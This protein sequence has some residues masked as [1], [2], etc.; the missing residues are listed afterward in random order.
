MKIVA[1]STMGLTLQ[2]AK[3]HSHKY[4]P[5]TQTEYYRVQAVFMGGYRPAQWIPQVER[6]RLEATAAQEAGP[7]P[8]M[9]GSIKRSPDA[10]RT[11]SRSRRPSV[12]DGPPIGW[13]RSPTR[14]ARMCE[15]PSRSRRTGG[16]R[17]SDISSTSSRPSCNPSRRRWPVCLPRSR[18][19]TATRSR[20]SRRRTRPTRLDGGTFRNPG[21]LRPPG[22][23]E[24]PCPDARRLS[25]SRPRGRA[26]G[27]VL[28][29]HTPAVPLDSVPE[30][31][32]HDR[33]S[34]GI[35]RVAD[36]TAAPA[37]GPRPGQSALAPSLRRRDR[38]HSRQLRIE[39]DSAEP[40]GIARL[41][42]DRVRRAGLVDQGDASADH[43]LVGLS[44]IEPR[45][46]RATHP[47]CVDPD[48]H[49][50]WRRRMAGSTPRRSGIRC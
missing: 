28:P 15:P 50:L 44:P 41:A 1:T 13:P 7:R 20:P 14:S 6:K 43:D 27:L 31:C 12:R 21:V 48:N 45:R 34:A 36:P 4:D 25:P 23:A 40:S 42:G 5:I 16:M 47:P 3:C 38:L 24:D 22:R 26:R 29:R 19:S 17:S 9:P 39:G 33:P 49:L 30:D 11:S 10:A 37:D 32:P 35:R 2:C 46:P 8:T 18:P